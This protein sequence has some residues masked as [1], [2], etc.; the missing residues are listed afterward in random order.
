[1]AAFGEQEADRLFNVLD[2]TVSHTRS[3]VT[4]NRPDLS[5]RPAQ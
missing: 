4:V 5:Y 1:M 2:E 3:F